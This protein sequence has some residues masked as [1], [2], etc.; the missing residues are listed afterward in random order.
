[1]PTNEN[2]HGKAERAL[3]TVFYSLL[4]LGVACFLLHVACTRLL[5]PYVYWDQQSRDELVEVDRRL[6]KFER[7]YGTERLR[8]QALEAGTAFEIP[9]ALRNARNEYQRLI[10]EARIATAKRQLLIDSLRYAA[11][12]FLGLAVLE[13]TLLRFAWR[14]APSD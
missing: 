11:I 1:M 7:A 12:V 4:A 14:S 3:V 13:A 6:E 9:V 5:D 2:N 8:L 10:V